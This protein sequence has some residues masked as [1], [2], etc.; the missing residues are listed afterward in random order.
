MTESM[1]RRTFLSRLLAALGVGAAGVGLPE[2]VGARQQD[3]EPLGAPPAPPCPRC[4]G[5]KVVDSGDGYLM[6]C[7]ECAPP[8]TAPITSTE[9]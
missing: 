1:K 9:L 7:L 8:I 4:G 3:D 5:T 2:R 6:R